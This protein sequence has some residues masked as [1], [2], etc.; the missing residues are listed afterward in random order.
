MCL[1]QWL[2]Q[3]LAHRACLIEWLDEIPE[4]TGANSYGSYLMD[5]A[6]EYDLKTI[7]FFRRVIPLYQMFSIDF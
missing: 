3:S 7:F 4:W 6:G 5:L 2:I 1:R